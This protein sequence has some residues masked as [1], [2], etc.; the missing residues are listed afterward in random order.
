MPFTERR[1]AGILKVKNAFVVI[2]DQKFTI[3]PDVRIM[4]TLRHTI[5]CRLVRQRRHGK[6]DIEPQRTVTESMAK[7]K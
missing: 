2:G 7:P 4:T 6:R 5:A 3:G 1:L